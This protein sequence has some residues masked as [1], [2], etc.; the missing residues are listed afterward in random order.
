MLDRLNRA[1]KFGAFSEEYER[2][3]H[4]IDW[5]VQIPWKKYTDDRIKLDE[6]KQILDDHHYGLEPVKQRI[7]E[8]LATVQLNLQQH[9]DQNQDPHETASHAPILCM[10]GLAGTGKTTF[11]YAL[12]KA[13]GR[14]ISRIPFGGLGSAR[15]IRGQSRLH[16]EAEPGHVVKALINAGTMNPVILLDEI[17]RVAD[18]ARADVMGVLLA[19]LDP[20]QNKTFIDHYVDFP[21]DLNQVLFVATCNNTDNLSTAVKNRLEV[22]QMPTYSDEEKIII[23]KQYLVP[24]AIKLAGLPEGSLVIEDHLW[25]QIVRPLGFDSGIRIL[26]RAVDR[27][28]RKAAF[29]IVQ[30]GAQKVVI[31]AEN[32]KDFVEQYY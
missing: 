12:A 11:A 7:L 22:I 17:D 9:Q 30:Q 29:L 6:A 13:M 25:P 26:K 31:N 28:V 8:F 23:A 21:I 27:L 24:E 10:V 3:S 2:T 20:G 16:L 14:K 15:D 18:E 4:Y 1:A 19:L 32:L 5:L